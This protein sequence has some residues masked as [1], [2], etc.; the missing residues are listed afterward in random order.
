MTEDKPTWKE[1]EF[2]SEDSVFQYANKLAE[3]YKQ[4]DIAKQLGCSQAAVSNMLSRK[5][6]LLQLAVR[7]I[8]IRTDLKFVR[9]N[10]QLTPYYKCTK[11]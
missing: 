5:S 1:S 10:E 6:K 2:L 11:Q 8:E 3:G 4:T 7:W 9:K